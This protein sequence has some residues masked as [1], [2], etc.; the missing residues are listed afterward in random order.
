MV[1]ESVNWFSIKQNI[2]M[3]AKSC[4]QGH[5]NENI[6]STNFCIYIIILYYLRIKRGR[7][8]EFVLAQY[9]RLGDHLQRDIHCRNTARCL[10]SSIIRAN[11]YERQVDRV[12]LWVDVG[13]KAGGAV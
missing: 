5:K 11:K 13:I 10:S 1:Q 3:L 7:V 12:N 8:L 2:A 4:I 9:T 6:S